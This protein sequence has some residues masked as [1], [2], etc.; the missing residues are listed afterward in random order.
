MS[1]LQYRYEIHCY[2]D[3]GELFTEE[4][5]WYKD[6]EKCTD[7]C[8]SRVNGKKLKKD[9]TES[10]CP[11]QCRIHVYVVSNEIQRTNTSFGPYKKLKTISSTIDP[12]GYDDT[13]EF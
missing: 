9:L 1:S 5:G 10:D 3:L 7:H 2:S 12:C 4:S 6:V 8:I 11:Y 13:Y